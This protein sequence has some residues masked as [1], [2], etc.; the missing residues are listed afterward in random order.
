MK[1]N[2]GAHKTPSEIA[3]EIF[4]VTSVESSFDK[5]G[6][7]IHLIA[8]LARSEFIKLYSPDT[9][10]TIFIQGFWLQF[11]FKEN[12]MKV[13]NRENNITLEIEIINNQFNLNKLKI[14]Y[15]NKVL[16]VFTS[17]K[18]FLTNRPNTTDEY[19]FIA[20][21]VIKVFHKLMNISYVQELN[22]F[23][24]PIIQIIPNDKCE[25]YFDANLVNIQ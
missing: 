21:S 25:I 9:T 15:F 10:V 4:K 2:S 20:K 18:I 13:L 11:I 19:Y 5:K 22:N 23:K 8:K 7:F 14:L 3:Q 17:R 16:G 1:S 24:Y 12:I 6:K